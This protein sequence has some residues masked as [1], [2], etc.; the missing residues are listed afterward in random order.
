MQRKDVK[1][2]PDEH[3]EQIPFRLREIM[4]SKDKM[5]MGSNKL[6]KMMRNTNSDLQTETAVDIPVPHF[7]RRK[8]ESESTYLQRMSRETQH[9]LFLTNNQMERQ[10][11]LQLEETETKSNKQKT[12][13]KKLS[14]KRRL[15]RLH[16]KKRMQKEER[17]E[18]EIF[19][20]EVQFGEVAME[21]PALTAKPRKAP[22]KSQGA[23]KGLLL[24]SLL[25]QTAL[26]TAKPSMARQR[27]MEEERER[28]VQAYRH[29]KRQKQERQEQQKCR[30]K[31]SRGDLVKQQSKSE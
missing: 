23:S 1:P 20:D 30:D 24:N 14:D 26:S 12:E 25:G 19:V 2:R 7:R 22:R 5:K 13:K 9:V 3:L 21:P 4:K 28:V 10:P 31:H 27:M 11:E 6:K 8:Q 15:E 16:N 17:D 18:K 29:L